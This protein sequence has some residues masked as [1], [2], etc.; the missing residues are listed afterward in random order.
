MNSNIKVSKSKHVFIMFALFLILFLDGFGQSLIF[1]ILT[2]TILSA[3]NNSLVNGLSMHGREVIYGLIVGLFYF[4]WMFGTA[5]LGDFSDSYGRKKGLIICIAGMIIGNILTV[6][7]F[8]ISNVWLVVIGRTII[9][10]TAGSQAIA[11]ASIADMST[12]ENQARNTGFIILAVTLGAI[13]GPAYG[14]VFSDSQICSLFNNQMPF[15]GVILLSLLSLLILLLFYRDTSTPNNKPIQLTRVINIFKD[16]FV[17]PKIRIL[18]LSMIS[19]FGCW[20]I[21]YTYMT[22]YLVKT[23]GASSGQIS[24]YMSMYGVGASISMAI[25]GGIVEK[26]FS[27]KQ[28]IV[29]GWTMLALATL[30]TQLSSSLTL[31]YVLAIFAGIGVAIGMLFSMKAFSVQVP[32]D[33]QGWIMGVFNASWV[34]VMGVSVMLMGYVAN[35]GIIVPLMIGYALYLIGVILFMSKVRVSL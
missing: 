12:P 10:F 17:H 34:G 7:A 11:Q 24:I 35:F 5:I 26:R 27:T 33:R 1:P 6:L 21:Y 28:A 25:L 18:L 20:S 16:A 14:Q 2:K 32:A 9:G 31:D 4:F 29:G 15:V 13:F 19:I 8:A 22:I 23:L 3:D 30:L